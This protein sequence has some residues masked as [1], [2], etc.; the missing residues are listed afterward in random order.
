M[1]VYPILQHCRFQINKKQLRDNETIVNVFEKS[2]ELQKLQNQLSFNLA[3]KNF[4]DR[5][6]PIKIQEESAEK[7]IE[8]SG[9]TKIF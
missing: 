7:E 2:G 6:I 9:E 5:L 8:A 3:F 4:F 1:V